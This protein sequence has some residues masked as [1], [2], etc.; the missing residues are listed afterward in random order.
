MSEDLEKQ[1]AVMQR[2]FNRERGARKQAESLLEGK[3]RELF[4][5]NESLRKLAEGLEREIEERTQELRDT[6]DAALAASRAKSAFLAN[7]SHEIRT[8][9]NGIIG[10][11]ELL[12]ETTLEP[13]QEHHAGVILESARALLAV[14]NDILDISKLEAGRFELER[15]P[16]DLGL[17][18][19][20]VL[21]TLAVPASAKGLALRFLP[22]MDL[23]RSLVGDAVRLRQVLINLAGNAVKFTDHGSVSLSVEVGDRIGDRVCLRFEVRD[24]GPGID[25]ADQSILFEKFSQLSH[26]TTGKHQG[27]GL[28][29]AISKTLVTMMGGRI[30]VDSGPGEGAAFW[31][32]AWLAVGAPGPVAQDDSRVVHALPRD[33]ATL[34]RRVF[35][36]LTGLA[37]TVEELSAF[38]DDPAPDAYERVVDRLFTEEPYRSRLAERLATPWMDAARFGD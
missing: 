36:D 25:S 22:G 26:P 9:M 13:E 15:D 11:T 27:T 34:L 33:P 2:R 4:E 1:L 16:F 38:L 30:G 31:F 29:L 28:G 8:P 5:A 18:L 19:D 20:G 14:I 35:L 6:R 17:V 12:L 23:P 32:T 3:S 7:M 37:P 10:M 24:T 21:D